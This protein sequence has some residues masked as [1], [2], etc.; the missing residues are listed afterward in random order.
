MIFLNSVVKTTEWH[1]N[2]YQRIKYLYLL[3]Y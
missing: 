1:N 2:L 3:G